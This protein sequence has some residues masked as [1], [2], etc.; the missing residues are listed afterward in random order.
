MRQVEEPDLLTEESREIERDQLRRR[1]TTKQ[2]RKL[3][4]VAELAPEEK[5]EV[6]SRLK[7]ACTNV[8][9]VLHDVFLVKAAR[10]KEKQ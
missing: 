3:G 8:S 1:L 6:E 10:S 5:E 4:H 7:K 9:E 2:S